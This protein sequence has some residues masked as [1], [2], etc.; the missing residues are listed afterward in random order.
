MTD[1]SSLIP[2]AQALIALCTERH[3]KIATAESCT[4]G[5]I[6]SG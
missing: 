6:A 2:T 1:L 4:G 5:L 3:L